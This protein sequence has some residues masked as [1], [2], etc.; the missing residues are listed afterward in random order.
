MGAEVNPGKRYAV[1]V[2]PSMRE[3]ICSGGKIWVK[4][5]GD[6]DY[7]TKKDRGIWGSKEE[8]QQQITE[9]YEIVV[10]VSDG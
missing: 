6:R 9:F 8:A 3:R 1:C 4:S 5:F 2:K 7:H 10:E